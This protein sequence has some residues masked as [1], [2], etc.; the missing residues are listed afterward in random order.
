MKT[1]RIKKLRLKARHCE[2]LG[3]ALHHLEQAQ[4]SIEEDPTVDQ[5]HPYILDL[6]MART[7]IEQAV[8]EE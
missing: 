8:E 3:E 7:L 2:H 4:R 5:R 1:P 6:M